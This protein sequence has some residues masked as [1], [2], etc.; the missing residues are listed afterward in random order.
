MTEL[1]KIAYAKSFIDKLA[2]GINPL[3]DTPIPED[4]IANNVRLSRCFFYV[5][6]ILQKEIDKE[7]RKRPK[8]KKPDK[9][10]FSITPEQ[11]QQFEY[12]TYPISVSAMGRKINWL[13]REDIE[14]KRMEKFPYRKINYWLRDIRMIE[15]REWENGKLRRFPTPEGE[16]IG[17]V[18]EFWEKYGRKTPVIYLSEEAQHF[19]IDNIEAVMAAEK[20]S[21]SPMLEENDDDGQDIAS[22]D[23]VSVSD[24]EAKESTEDR[25]INY[26][27][28]EAREEVQIDSNKKSIISERI[29]KEEAE[30]VE[31]LCRNC[32]FQL[33]GECSSWEPCDDFQP[34]YIISQEERDNWPTEGDAT[35]FKQKWKKR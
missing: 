2:N 7:R 15:W 24:V 23:S 26:Y 17:L 21:L 35:R 20:G 6:S 33:S 29:P 30:P 12:S 10:P 27:P 13:V 5:S 11:L 9:L 19:I 14:E 4:D 8:E 3:D 28:L 22:D 31:K 32:R 1:E 34:V 16:S 25:E 18:L